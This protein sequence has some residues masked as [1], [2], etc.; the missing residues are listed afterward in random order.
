M[1]AHVNCTYTST[2]LIHLLI[3]LLLLTTL[4]APP[5]T[6]H[7][8]A[9]VVTRFDDP[10]P[11]SCQPGDCSLR[12]AIIAANASSGRD[13]IALSPG[14]Y[15]LSIAGRGEDAGTAGD[16]DIASDITLIG[17]GAGVTTID[18]NQID[19]VLDILSGDV[20]IA[21]VALRHGAAG[22]RNSGGGIRNAGV[23]TLSA[24]A[25]IS[26]S[27]GIFL[28]F[29]GGAGGGIS[30]TG[31]LQL[32]DSTISGNT[33][34]DSGGGIFSTGS[35]TVTHSLLADNAVGETSGGAL[36]TNGHAMI[37][38][39]VITRNKT[40]GA[41][42]GIG[43]RGTLELIDCQ[44]TDNSASEGQSAGGGIINSGTLTVTS[45]LISHNK[46]T[47]TYGG[48]LDNW[49]QAT[50]IGSAI[51]GNSA[52]DG[53]GGVYNAAG[54]LMFLN[55]AIDAN[56]SEYGPTGIDNNATLTLLD[57][58]VSA[59][60][61]S[62]SQVITATNSTFSAAAIENTGR[63][64]FGNATITNAEL[65]M[66]NSGAVE[67]RNTILAGNAADCAGPI[68]SLGHNLLGNVTGCSYAEASGDLIGTSA[69]PI[70]PRLGPLQRN[71]GA[72]ATHA[73]L[74]GSPAV[75]AG[76]DATC[77]LVD[78][79]GVARPQGVACDIGAVEL[80]QHLWLYLPVIRV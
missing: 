47:S 20:S 70:N 46:I 30:S 43:N 35:L 51:Q 73:P 68:V 52:F 12:E 37:R 75:D 65:A 32:A 53:P 55:S 50:F 36:E 14:T 2:R 79:R 26:S 59:N 48:G 40:N 1:L 71:G 77:T 4:V 57:S 74:P 49:G 58:T 29:N 80:E 67:L 41:G 18:A 3:A 23:L 60:S 69:Q 76:D 42:G 39:S 28:D 6:T 54:S 61:I 63:M 66:K 19:R 56:T 21:A 78:Q 16:L 45:C 5:N 15:T 72:T 7:A 31:T 44:I 38:D 9:L 34:D 24:S 10:A 27:A 25:V 64:V 13:T 33:S 62:N 17:A 8:A 11:N 22:S